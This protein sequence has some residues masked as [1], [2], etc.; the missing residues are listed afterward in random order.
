MPA[1]TKSDEL[2]LLGERIEA[3]KAHRIALA[4]FEERAPARQGR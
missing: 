2:L 1:P 4:F 3:R